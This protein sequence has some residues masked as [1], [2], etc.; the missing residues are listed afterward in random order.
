[1]WKAS[2]QKIHLL[3]PVQ[4]AN[5]GWGRIE[6]L[7]V[8]LR[9]SARSPWGLDGVAGTLFA[10]LLLGLLFASFCSL[11][12]LI[13]SLRI[14]RS[15]LPEYLNLVPHEKKPPP[16]MTL[17]FWLFGSVKNSICSMAHRHT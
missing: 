2:R 8:N 7:L 3:A 6:N 15:V 16:D 1:M 12:A 17:A 9:I 10:F 13:P 5:K 4:S 11:S 14:S